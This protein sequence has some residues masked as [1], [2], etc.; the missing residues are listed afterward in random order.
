MT[1]A[2]PLWRFD[3][4]RS[5]D[6]VLDAEYEGGT[7]GNTGDDPLNR[8]LPVGNQ[9]GFRYKG[10]PTREGV[11]LVVLYTSGE[12]PDWP[13]ALDEKTGLFTYYGDN[14][15]PGRLLHETPRSGNV[16]LRDAFA[17]A[18]AD[19]IAR[20]QVPPFLLFAKANAS[21]R[22]VVFRGLI[23]PGADTL[24]ADDDLQAIWRSTRGQRF[25]NYRAAFTVLDTPV[26]SRAWIGQ[27]LAG[28]PLG[29][30]CPPAWAEWVRGRAYRT[31]A[32]PATKVVRSRAEQLPTD[33]VGQQILS[34]IHQHFADRWSDF[35]ACAV[36]LWRMMA[37]NTG[38]T[39]VTRAS[40]DFGRDAIGIYQL[41]PAADR[42]TLDFVLEAKCYGPDNSVGVKETSRLISR[43]RHRMF[44]VLVTTSYVH[45]QAYSE[46]REDQHPIVIICGRDIVDVLQQKGYT[47][48][49]AVAAWLNSAFPPNAR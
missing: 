15:S 36:E 37:P 1:S 4:L 39:A 20:Q 22:N 46:V 27:I 16:I 45:D 35:E 28:Q 42:I 38:V 31:L 30:A 13:D 18:H 10:S 14:R 43:I 8:L 3:Q 9:G 32:A 19:E 17:A 34:T 12:N 48:P 23:A 2:R 49:A 29:D 25:Q 7:A 47:T 6:L 5:A 40:R 24:A 41:G 33:A 21:G 26:V 44:G 11:K